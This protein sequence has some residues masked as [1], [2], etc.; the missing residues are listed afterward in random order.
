MARRSYNKKRGKKIQPAPLNMSFTAAGGT[1]TNWIDLSQCA[2]IVNRRF[3]RQGINW[4]VAGFTVTVT[5]TTTSPG[6]VTISKVPN[7]WM[8]SNAWHKSFAMWNKMNDMVLDDDPSIKPRYH[9]FK[10]YLNR[11][12]KDATY[13]TDISAPVDEQILLPTD[14]AYNLPVRGEWEYSTIQ[15]PNVLA[16]GTPAPGVTSEFTLHFLDDA[17]QNSKGMIQG[18]AHSRARPQPVDPNVTTVVGTTEPENWMTGLFDVGDNLPDIRDNLDDDNDEPPYKVGVHGSGVE[19][20]PGSE[21]Q[22]SAPEVVGY[23]VISNAG[24]SNAITAQR[25]IQG[26]NFPCGLIQIDT[27]LAGV[28]SYDIVVHLVPGIHKGYLCE[29]MQDM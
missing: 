13:Q 22:L 12:M 17:T 5:G 23:A 21:S 10:V 1:A 24:G 25:K 19:Y 27:A 14:A 28:T 16:D 9:D 15:M 7:T 18:Y 8:A 26:A 20:Y 29:P 3:Y 11:D 2:S 6:S 4:A